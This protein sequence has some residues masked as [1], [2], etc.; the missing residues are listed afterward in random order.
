MYSSLRRERS[1]GS[2]QVIEVAF[3]YGNPRGSLSCGDFLLFL[4]G[5]KGRLSPQA[6]D[7]K[8]IFMEKTSAQQFIRHAA[9]YFRIY[10]FMPSVE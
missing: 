2:E 8:V 3:L 9:V 5:K 7:L 4:I 10:L 6:L 1:S